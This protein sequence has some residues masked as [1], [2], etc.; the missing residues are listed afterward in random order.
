MVRIC[1]ALLALAVIVPVAPAQDTKRPI[2]KK[3]FNKDN[4]LDKEFLVAM[5]SCGNAS[6]R[7]IALVENRT[8]SDEVKA[9]AKK[10]KEDHDALGKKLADTLKA[11]KLVTVAGLDKD[12][13]E[14]I[15]AL[16]KLE[17]GDFDKE[18]LKHTIE[19]HEKVIKMAEH[20]KAKGTEKD[21]T[22]FAEEVLTTM[23]DHLK[24]AKELQKK[25][26]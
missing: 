24:K 3:E 1:C 25:V 7:C 12:V 11:H 4:P 22:A 18:F 6:G 10:L 17:K 23:R 8:A 5:H 16:G 13:N 14:K 9:F 15:T 2:E 19:G 21:I 26:G 20:Q